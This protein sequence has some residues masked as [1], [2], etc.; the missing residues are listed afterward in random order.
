MSD[1][2]RMRTHIEETGTR[3]VLGHMGSD[4]GFH[5]FAQRYG[6]GDL[7][8]ISDPEQKLYS[9]LGLRRGTLMQLLS[10]RML[11]R[12]LKAA[13]SG[14][15]PGRSKGDIFQLPGA[16]LIENRKIIKAYPYQDASDRPNYIELATP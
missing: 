13:C 4:E 16:F 12:W 9:G 7:M 6:L 8:S 1:I 11:W 10:P 2:A 3:I 15:R 5:E 14:H